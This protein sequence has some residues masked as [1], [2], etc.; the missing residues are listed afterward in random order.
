MD[1]KLIKMVT[2]ALVVP[3]LVSCGGSKVVTETTPEEMGLNLV[4]I[5]EESNNSVLAGVVYASTK[6]RLY[7]RIYGNQSRQNTAQGY[8]KKAKFAW[9]ALATLAISPD[10]SK[11]A[12]MTNINEQPNVMVRRAA[13]GGVATQRTFRNVVDMS[14]GAD[15]RLYFADSNGESSYICSVNA[16]QGNMVTQLTNGNVNDKNPVTLDGKTIFFTRSSKNDPYVWSLDRDNGTLTSCAPGYMP[17][18][19]PGDPESFYCVR[20][21]STGRS[22]IWHVNFVKGQESLLLSDENHSFTHP[23]LS[24][25]GK[26]IAVQG[27]TKSSKDKKENLDIYVV[28]TDGSNLTQLTY[29]SHQDV[30]PVFS[31]DGKSIFFISD[32]GNK[33]EMYNVWRMNFRME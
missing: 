4:K 10:G 5:T 24:P 25:D 14:W 26:W 27:N 8:C 13:S 12:Y 16:E 17:C 33:K 22:E 9:N 2:G 11:L 3:F 28:R 30:C 29:D 20:N 23:T 15:E 32:R 31:K 1:M 18:P 7:S 6:D 21:S 19:V